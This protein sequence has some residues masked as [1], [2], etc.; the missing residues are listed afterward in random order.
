[1]DIPPQISLIP[2]ELH[3]DTFYCLVIIVCKKNLM[4]LWG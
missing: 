2:D 1:M 3:L 4:V